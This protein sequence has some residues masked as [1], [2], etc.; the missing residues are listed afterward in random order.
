MNVSRPKQ[1]LPLSQKNK[2]W[3]EANITYW[4]GRCNIYP[5]ANS[6][7]VALYAAAAGKLDESLY[8]YVTNPLN[9]E[10]TKLKGYPAKMRNIDIISPNILRIMGELSDRY[11][12]PIV[13][14]INEDVRTK[15]DQQEHELR[16]EALKRD[17]INGLVERG[18]LA[19]DAAQQPLPND[20]LNKTVSSLRSELSKMGQE[21]INVIMKENE[22]LKIRRKT[23]YDFI[24]LSRMYTYRDIRGNN[25]YYD[26]ISPLEISF[27]NNPNIDF[28]ED[29]E[30]VRRAVT[31]PLNQIVD[32]MSDVEGFDEILPELEQQIA[33]VGYQSIYTGL[34]SDML[35]GIFG[36][37]YTNQS[38]GLFFEHVVWSSLKKMLRV[39]G[40]DFWGT[41]YT[42]DYDESYIPL[43]EESVE[44]FWV[45][46]KW[47][48]YR[49]H[50]KHILGVE[51][52]DEQRGT[53][54]APNKC[55]NPYNGRI[56]LNNYIVPQSMVEKG[57]VYQIKYNIV[58]Y[59]LE[60][61]LNKNKDKILTLPLG[62]VPQKEGWDE[63]TM[64]YYADAHGY[65]FMDETNPQTLTALQYI[66]SIDMSLT[67]YIKE[68]YGIL[69]QIKAD[70][71]DAIGFTPQRKAQISASAGKAVTEMAISNS[72][73]VTEEF[74]LQ[75]EEVIVKD[76]Q[77]LMDLSRI[78]WQ[79]GK[80]GSYI[81]NEYK[82]ID[83]E[84]NPEVYCFSEMSVFVENGGK[85]ARE[86]EILKNQ[87]GTIAQQTQNFSILPRI[88]Q[89][90][91]I[92]KLTEQ[93]EEIE[94]RL[95][96]TQAAQAEKEN[97][98][99][100]QAN[101]L[102]AEEMELAKYKI[103]TDNETKKEVEIIR[104]QGA[105]LALQTGEDA[106]EGTQDAIKLQELSLKRMEHL[107]KLQVE[108][109]KIQES[110][111][112]RITE[113]NLARENMKNDLQIANKNAQNR[114]S[115]KK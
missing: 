52:L 16:I 10:K 84:I 115:T 98:L 47:H 2:E 4:A 107:E 88:V 46:E 62:I 97:A 96:E 11:F 7:A 32:L 37:P 35:R 81:N 85:T 112:K 94:R 73:T 12:N 39:S 57:I 22:V 8:T 20:I 79:D 27:P 77:C 53:Y 31:L 25:L 51:P 87:I 100:E 109:E 61:L 75:H 65:L 1:R 63:F 114:S 78:A 58:H 5:I 13:V 17:F 23:L 60:K 26:W 56:F 83:V 93:L 29:A 95:E 19:E 103:D 110:K 82:Q 6:D 105:I 64:M 21:A 50:N 86:L 43:P 38:E 34:T 40:K 102:K 70:W 99:A 91:N 42:V 104:Q 3:R 106:V 72:L 66:K 108:K 89:A 24:V 14:A 92:P 41:E 101:A 80:K 69:Q 68:V 113:A 15:V 59:H 28:V 48:G 74:F 18:M 71:D 33:T 67:S 90:T 45:T 9:E 76:L 111:N 30:A 49:I 36:E 55:K 54:D 44:E